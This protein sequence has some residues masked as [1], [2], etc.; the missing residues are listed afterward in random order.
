MPKEHV[1]DEYGSLRTEVLAR[2]RER[3]DL[4]VV[5][6]TA[7][8]ALF[9]YAVETKNGAIF[10]CT[11]MLLFPA[12]IHYAYSGNS[13]DGVA[14]YLRVFHEGDDTDGWESR[15]ARLRRTGA[16]GAGFSYVGL[17]YST[18]YFSVALVSSI[19]AFSYL[20]S[21]HRF[22]WPVGLLGLWCA[23]AWRINVAFTSR[24][25]NASAELVAQWRAVANGEDDA[26]GHEQRV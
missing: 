23:L 5:V 13:F 2:I 15:L 19:A 22:V 24:Y 14:C 6:S 21:W 26:T 20:S 4:M 16:H 3:F 9:G 8:A 7:S 10:L 11:Y 18:L 17:G 1:R 12:I 25:R